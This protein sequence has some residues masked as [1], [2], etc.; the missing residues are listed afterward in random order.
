LFRLIEKGQDIGQFSKSHSARALARFIFNAI[1][2]LR[3]TS[4][5]GVDKKVFDD[6]VKVTVSALK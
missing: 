2:G 5:S 1:S 3:V 6:I 4:K